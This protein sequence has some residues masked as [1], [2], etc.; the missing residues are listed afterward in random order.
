MVDTSNRS[1][2]T[3][4]PN[5]S[6]DGTLS[7]GPPQSLKR[8]RACIACRNMKTKCISVP[9]SNDCEACLRYSRPCQDPGPPKAR[10]K[11]SQ[12]FT[13][14]EKR[15]DALTS[16][17]DAERRRNQQLPK[18]VTTETQ[19]SNTPDSIPRDDDVFSPATQQGQELG[20]IVNEARELA[21]RSDVVDQGVIDMPTAGLLFDHWKFH[22]RPF[23]PV[24]RFSTNENA[25]TIRAKRPILFLTIMTIAGTAIKP[26][27]VPHLL[28]QLNNTLAQDVFIQGAKSLDL[29]QAMILFSQYYIQPPQVKAFAMPQHAYSAVIMSH[30]LGLG[31]ANR[32]DESNNREKKETYR[33]LLAVYLGASWLVFLLPT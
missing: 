25:H 27:I 12:K 16:A 26:S 7:N 21:I 2:N 13:D 17:L 22:M 19:W 29:L 6:E 18:Q 24:I 20:G 30:D 33:T 10:L 15:I 3:A 23:M 9:G 4:Y 28:T 14:L 32:G 31:T 5:L 1:A 8:L 11:T